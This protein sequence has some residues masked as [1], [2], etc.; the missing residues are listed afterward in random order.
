MRISPV[1]TGEIG[2]FSKMAIPISDVIFYSFFTRFSRALIQFHDKDLH[3][4]EDFKADLAAALQAPDDTTK[5]NQ[6]RAFFSQ[7]GHAFAFAVELG[8]LLH[9]T[10][11]TVISSAVRSQLHR[12]YLHPTLISRR[13]RPNKSN[14][15]VICAAL[16]R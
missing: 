3:P 2:L 8:G 13:D 12:T 16:C 9:T 10:K 5:R 1:S 15:N 4:T 11:E 7:Y 14:K 6:I